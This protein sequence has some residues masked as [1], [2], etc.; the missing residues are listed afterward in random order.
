MIFYE[1]PIKVACCKNNNNWTLS[2]THNLLIW[3]CKKVWSLKVYYIYIY[4]YMSQNI[5]IRLCKWRIFFIHNC[6]MCKCKKF[7]CVSV[8]DLQLH[9]IYTLYIQLLTFMAQHWSKLLL[10]FLFFENCQSRFHISVSY[11]LVF[12]FRNHSTFH[13]Q[14]GD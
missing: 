11:P 1:G 8:I 13:A 2:C 5:Y 6:N 10:W 9:M 14:I 4:I 12:S 3:V 7:R